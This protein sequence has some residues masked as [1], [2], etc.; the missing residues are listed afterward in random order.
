MAPPETIS[1]YQLNR[2]VKC[3]DCGQKANGGAVTETSERTGWREIATVI[4]GCG[5]RE[6]RPVRRKRK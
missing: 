3:P 4:C 6:E 5:W 2:G 1:E